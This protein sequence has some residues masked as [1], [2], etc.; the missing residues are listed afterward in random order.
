[1]KTIKLTEK[2]AEW[3]FD[4]MVMAEASGEIF[5]TKIMEKITEAREDGI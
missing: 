5:A 1:M 4:Y 2:E 3:L